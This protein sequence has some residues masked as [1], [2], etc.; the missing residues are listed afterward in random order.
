M[1]MTDPA[2]NVP[3]SFPSYPDRFFFEGMDQSLPDAFRMS[4]VDESERRALEALPSVETRDLLLRVIDARQTLLV[5]LANLVSWNDQIV[6]AVREHKPEVLLPV[7]WI[8]ITGDATK[9]GR[10]VDT[11]LEQSTDDPRVWSV[12]TELL[13]GMF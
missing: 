6:Q 13:D 11:L 4:I 1:I 5:R 8:S 7:E 3:F 9:G 12:E 2:G 10:G